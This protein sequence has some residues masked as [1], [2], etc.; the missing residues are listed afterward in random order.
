MSNGPAAGAGEILSGPATTPPS[1]DGAATR[2]PRHLGVEEE[3]QLVDLTTRRLAP[4]APEM[5]ALLGEQRSYVAEMQQCVIEVNSDVVTSLD[6]LQ[7]ELVRHRRVLADAAGS[8][9][10]GIAAA[11]TVPLSVPAELSITSTAR[12]RRMLADYQLLARQQLICGTQVHVEVPDRDEATAV[13]HRIAPDLPVFL[14]L[15][16]SSPFASDGTDSGYASARTLIWSR[17]PT[18]GLTS[19]VQ[20]A[21]ELDQLTEQLVASGV[22]S[23]PGMIYFDVRASTRVPTLELRIC[24]SCP[25]VDT[26]VL[27]AGLF[28]AL[29]DRELAAHRAG[30]PPF[31]MSTVLGRAATWR[32]ARSGLEEDLVDVR[33][34]GVARPASEVVRSLVDGLRPWL[35]ANG[36]WEQVTRLADSALLVGSSAARQRRALRRRGRLTDVVDLLVAETRHGVSEQVPANPGELLLEYPTDGY[37]EALEGGCP[38]PQYRGL[39]EAVEELGSSGLRA[40]DQAVVQLSRADGITFKVTG[41]KEPQVFP[42]DLV[43]RVVTAEDWAHISAGGEQRARALDA[44]LRDVYDRREIVN[45]GVIPAELLDRAP[46]YRSTGRV[47]ISSVRAHISGLDLVSSGPG[48]WQVL[49]DNLR[50]PSGV[51]YAMSNRYLVK[52]LLPELVPPCEVLDSRLVPGMLLETLCAAAP[53]GGAADP[54]EV[55]VLSSGAGD[56]AW[57]EHTG[58]ARGMGVQVVTPEQVWFQDGDLV[59][60]LDGEV[61]P[62]RVAY[63]RMDEDMLLSSKDRDGQLLRGGLSDALLRGRLRIANALGNGVGDDKAVYAYVPQMVEYYL[64]EK[65]L[66]E[67]VPTF[68]CAERDQAESVLGRLDELVTKPIDGYGGMGVLIGPDA[69]DEQ[70]SRRRDEI[71]ANPERYVAQEVVDLSTHPTFDGTHLRPRHIDLRVFVHLRESGEKVEAVTMP[72]ALTRVGPAGSKVVNSSAGGGSKDTWILAEPLAQ[73]DVRRDDEGAN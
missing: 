56:S 33:G 47:P 25:S 62:I 67:Q 12:Y 26:I 46:G 52:K 29:V 9:G 35:E 17:W 19:G 23:D 6:E 66:M 57:P 27:V 49:E 24:D 58:L 28:R 13:A 68:L 71:L 44:F 43:P 37:D 32:A 8:V 65:P 54:S 50:V 14:A 73:D 42:L 55:V 64:G 60:D 41:R 70:L 21:A 38:R 69:S 40:R 20:S 72:A 53:G 2:P 4:R 22:I 59:R 48:R 11:G 39:L 18:T 30:E 3:F 61:T 5:L 63:V 34:G 10:A 31:E 36:D 45:D 51:G 1:H 16:A 7:V 15:S